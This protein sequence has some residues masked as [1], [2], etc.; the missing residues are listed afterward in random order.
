MVVKPGYLEHG[1]AMGKAEEVGNV[2]SCQRSYT[3][4]D[5]CGIARSI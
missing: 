4:L 3:W 2:I 5:A 1:A